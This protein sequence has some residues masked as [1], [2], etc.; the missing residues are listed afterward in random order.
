MTAPDMINLL[1][2]QTWEST[3]KD[4]FKEASERFKAN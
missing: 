1:V 4:L 2:R 3:M